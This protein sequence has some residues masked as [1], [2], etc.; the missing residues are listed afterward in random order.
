MTEWLTNSKTNKQYRIANRARGYF[1]VY[2]DGHTVQMGGARP[3]GFNQFNEKNRQWYKNADDGFTAQH[4]YANGRKVNAGPG[5]IWRADPTLQKY[6]GQG[7][8]QSELKYGVPQQTLKT[9][10]GR[11]QGAQ[12]QAYG[13]IANYYAG[14]SGNAQ[15]L[16][17]QAGQVGKQTDASLQ[18]IGA[19]R[20]AQ[21]Q[22][23]TPQFAGPLGFVAQNLVNSETQSALNRGNSVDAAN[24]GLNAMTSGNRQAFLGQMGAAQQ[25]AGQERLSTLKGQGQQALNVY[26][27]KIAELERQKALGAVDT[28]N[29]LRTADQTYGLNVAKLQQQAANDQT[30][31]AIAQQ[32]A[33]ANTLRAGNSG[34]SG[35]SGNS[36]SSGG[37][38]Y[39]ATP[40][41]QRSFS[42]KL[43]DAVTGAQGQAKAIK[44]LSDLAGINTI[45]NNFH[46]NA[47]QAQVAQE[48][49]K[50]GGIRRS[51]LAKVHRL[52]YGIGSGIPVLPR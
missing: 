6:Y 5:S 42:S 31:N 25:M 30:Q 9:Q 40:A 4:V 48:Y 24:R 10:M 26:A 33:D 34:S 22:G 7:M 39:G 19:T 12:N 23:A 1:H 35:G 11:E 20:N 49:I 36:G 2:K 41:Q 21:I 32:N 18:S 46:V 51:T 15:H 47:L 16:M 13:Q 37:S 29:Q 17:D 45:K 3:Q 8:A 28:A 27:D 44:G 50:Y 52:G 38:P 43:N 14:L